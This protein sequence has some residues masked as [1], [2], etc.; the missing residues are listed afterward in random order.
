M[1]AFRTCRALS[2]ARLRGAGGRRRARVRAGRRVRG[3]GAD[4][5]AL[6]DPDAEPDADAGSRRNASPDPCRRPWAGGRRDRAQREPDLHPRDARLPAPWSAARDAL[7]AIKPSFYRLV[8]DWAS[9]QPSADAPADLSAPNGGCM[10]AIG[11]CLGYAGVRDQLRALASRQREGG[12]QALAVLTTTPDWAAAP[13][14]GCER[15]GTRDRNRPPRAE[16]L[17]RLPAADRRRA[18][19]GERGGRRPALL[20]RLE[21]AEPPG[22]R[23]PAARHLR[24]HLAEPRRR[25][26]RRAHPLADPGAR[27]RRPASSRSSSARPRAT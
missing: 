27:P 10:R 14:A 4:A 15:P 26:V 22:V 13:P 12:W 24:H 17:G 9:V 25:P 6:A 3:R 19:G 1:E 23:Q 5:H 20:E 18:E 8:I 7:G 2:P 21:R 16:A 11:P